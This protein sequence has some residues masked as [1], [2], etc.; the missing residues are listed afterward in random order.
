MRLCW[1]YRG[2]P[3]KGPD[4]RVTPGTTRGELRLA[5]EPNGDY[6]AEVAGL[7]ESV[8]F[9]VRAEDFHTAPRDIILLQP[10]M[11]T[12]LTR[13][14]YQPAYLYHPAPEEP[15]PPTAGSPSVRGPNFGALKGLR[16][17]LG[18]KDLSLTGDRS[19][20]TVPAG[21]DLVLVGTADKPLAQVFLVPKVGRVPG[22]AR[23]GCV[24]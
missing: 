11:L 18:E 19:L 6:A 5:R 8:T 9:T 4:G 2:K 20:C 7:K 3:T 23:G 24:G 22:A 12:R 15:T 13:T 14:E 17:A 21:T 10:P 16:Q 1:P